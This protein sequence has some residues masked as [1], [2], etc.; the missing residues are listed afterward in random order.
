MKRTIRFGAF[1]TNSSSTHTLTICSK[2]EFDE[3]RNGKVVYDKWEGEFVPI[4]EPTERELEEFG[5]K[6]NELSPEEKEDVKYDWKK[7]MHPGLMSYDEWGED[8]YLESYERSY[9][10]EH[11]DEIVVFGMYGYEG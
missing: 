5:Y 4:I 9:T 11:G 6:Y 7:E 1:E 3:W 8:D 10:T 2:K